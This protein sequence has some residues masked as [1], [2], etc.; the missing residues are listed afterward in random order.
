MEYRERTIFSGQTFD[1]P[2]HVVRLDSKNTH[3]WQ[4]RYGKWTLFSDHSLDG[5][6]AARA[7]MEA[8][9]ELERRIKKLPAPHGIRSVALAGK[10]NGMPVGISGPISRQR[11]GLGPVQYYLQVTFPV[12]GGKPANRSVYIATENTLTREKYR[13]A[14]A[15]ANALR[16]TGV[17]KYKLATTKAKREQS[18]ASSLLF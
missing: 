18:G 15:K 1:V 17:R 8:S 4:L 6:G 14:L 7:L 2:K 11:Q 12:S 9:A 5:S 16:D 10:A 3:G 13:L